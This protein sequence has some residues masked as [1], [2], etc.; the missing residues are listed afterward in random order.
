MARQRK[1]SDERRNLIDKLLA[2][3][4]PE[5]AEGVQSMLKGLLGDTLERMLE[6]ELEDDLSYS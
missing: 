3:Y 1:L 6:A 5:D 4:N 2:T